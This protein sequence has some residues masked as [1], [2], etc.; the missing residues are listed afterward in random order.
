[1][2]AHTVLINIEGDGEATIE[3]GSFAAG[4][5]VGIE[6]KLKIKG[7]GSTVVGALIGGDEVKLEDGGRL[8]VF[9]AALTAGDLGTAGATAVLGLPGSKVKVSDKASS[10]VGDVGLSP[11]SEQD[12]DKGTINGALLV[13]PLADNSSSNSVVITGGTITQDMGLA[14]ADAVDASN[15]LARLDPDISIAEIKSSRTIAAVSDLTVIDSKKVE[16]KSGATLT[17]SGGPS[18]TFVFNLDEKIKLE[19]GSSVVLTGGVTP[20]NVIFNVIGDNDSSIESGSSVSGTILS[21][22]GKVKVKDSGSVLYGSAISGEEAVV[23]KG[24]TVQR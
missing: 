17:I 6:A 14:A 4:T 15:A 24:A 9:G 12:F 20:D 13:D 10:I 22:L 7:A 3:N 16:L 5:I 8:R 18:S 23:E 19:N 2:S 11:Y 21:P 1:V